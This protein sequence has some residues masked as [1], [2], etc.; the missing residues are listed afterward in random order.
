MPIGVNSLELKAFYKLPELAFGKSIQPS[1]KF[2]ALFLD[3]PLQSFRV[4]SEPGPMPVLRPYHIV[5]VAIPSFSFEKQIMMYGQVPRT[6]PVLNFEGFNVSVT[7]EEDELGTIEYF[8]NWCTR[9]IINREGLYRHPTERRIQAFVVEIQDKTGIP[10][11]Y[12]IF[13]DLYFLDA[14]SA[15]YS[16]ENNS[17]IKR[18]VTFGV[19]RM[20]T[21]F[22][23]YFLYAGAIGAT[24]GAGISKIKG[25]IQAARG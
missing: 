9:S 6:F 18:N 20:T 7:F 19:D 21:V 3:N 10:I 8:I 12:Y 25:V 4:N 17:A 16:Y 1:W 11:V 13:H 2:Y 15:S 22:T 24:A 14:S 23:K 5:D